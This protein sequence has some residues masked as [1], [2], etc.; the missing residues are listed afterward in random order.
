MV[1]LETLVIDKAWRGRGV[2]TWALAQ[3]LALNELR[4]AKARYLWV[5]PTV[6]QP[7]WGMSEEEFE[8]EK[9]RVIRFYRKEGFRRVG[10]SIFFCLA[11]DTQHVSRAIPMDED[12]P[13]VSLPYRERKELEKALQAEIT[14][15]IVWM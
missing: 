3:L 7:A 1:F 13:S 2:G 6:Y 5:W 11:F 12:A 15:G 8:R 10:T 4:E 14:K 9:N